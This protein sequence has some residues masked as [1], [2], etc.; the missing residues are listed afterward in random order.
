MRAPTRG[1]G[2]GVRGTGQGSETRGQGSADPDLTPD[3]RPLAP[4]SRPSPSM[5]P[6]REARFYAL[7]E[8]AR[9]AGVTAAFFRSWRID[10]REDET[11]VSVDAGARRSL[12]F[13][14]A[15]PSFWDDL[16]T[17]NFQTARAGWMQP[18]PE[19][20]RTLVPDFVVPFAHERRN[21]K[22]PLFVA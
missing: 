16:A 14:N 1:Q 5:R 19:Q 8:L 15:P 18:P 10:F 17:G 2:S 3:P 11:I 21:D 13:L 4:A 22:S 20:V 9:R 12:R 7:R 6:T